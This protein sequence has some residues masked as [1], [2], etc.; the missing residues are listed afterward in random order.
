[1]IVHSGRAAGYVRCDRTWGQGGQQAICITHTRRHTRTWVINR[2][3]LHSCGLTMHKN[4][5]VPCCERERGSGFGCVLHNTSRFAL[6][7]HKLLSD[8]FNVRDSLHI[9]L[10]ARTILRLARIENVSGVILCSVFVLC[11]VS[12]LFLSYSLVTMQPCLL[13]IYIR[14]PLPCIQRSPCSHHL[15]Y[16]LTILCLL[17]PS[18]V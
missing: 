6:V 18:Y 9:D 17:Q 10:L 1:M 12:W 8:I 7:T 13:R 11:T 5:L 16:D 3:V 4:T 2:T 15:M 14:F